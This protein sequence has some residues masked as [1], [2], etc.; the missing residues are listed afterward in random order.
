MGFWKIPRG[1]LGA[2]CYERGHLKEGGWGGSARYA[3]SA[4]LGKEV[5]GGFRR[6]FGRAGGR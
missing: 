1:G 6:R 4:A 2:L 5:G 3:R